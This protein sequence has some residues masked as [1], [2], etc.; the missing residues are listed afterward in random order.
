MTEETELTATPTEDPAVLK[1]RELQEALARIDLLR[2]QVPFLL[3]QV[4]AARFNKKEPPLEALN[5]IRQASEE[6]FSLTT[7][8]EMAKGNPAPSRPDWMNQTPE[9]GQE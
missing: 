1:E 2:Q 9:G 8:I 5:G 4:E 6:Y 7:R 3:L